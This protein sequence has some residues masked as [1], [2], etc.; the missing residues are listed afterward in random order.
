MKNKYF[1]F[2]LLLN[3]L[4]I[5]SLQSCKTDTKEETTEQ[6]S[7][8]QHTESI[9][10]VSLPN[11]TSVFTLGEKIQFRLAFDSTQ[12]FNTLELYIDE[13]KIHATDGKIENY[14]ISTDSLLVGSHTFSCKIKKEGQYVD[15]DNCNFILLSDIVPEEGN[16]FIKR[17]FPHDTHAYT[18]G[19][20]YE[21][22]KLYEGTGM[23]GESMLKEI[24]PRNG[25]T[26]REIGIPEEYFGEGIT[27]VGNKIVQLTWRTNIG[28][29]YEKSTF[30]KLRE[31]NYPTEGWGLT[32]DGTHLIMTDGSENMYFMDTAN[33]TVLK[34]IQ[35]Y[36][37]NGPI[38]KL[39][40]LEYVDG[41]VYANIYTTDFI[42][43]IDPRTGKVIKRW[44][45]P[46]MLEESDITEQTDV[47][48]GI[49]YNKDTKRFYITGKY[50][51]KMFEIAFK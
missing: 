13:K 42:V 32:F 19:L 50:W 51:P 10:K 23:N 5:T 44:E 45:F 22:G 48:N 29:V 30:K 3:I 35:V 20:Q 34:K 21:N 2:A 49:A 8:Q 16:F 11:K 12:H 47:L 15:V 7:E 6:P 26:I 24:S 1:G 9:V 31:F 17:T 40:E 27:I 33:Y 38:E 28:F 14:T 43:K 41:Y 46:D 4:L 39:N 37:N 36:D 25:S 18:Q